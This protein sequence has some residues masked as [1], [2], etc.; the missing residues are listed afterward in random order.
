MASAADTELGDS[1]QAT[2]TLDVKGLNCPLPILKTKQRLAQ[3]NPGE[4][5]HILATDP[6]STIDFK[7]FCLRTPHELLEYSEQPDLFQF[8]I[9]KA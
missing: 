4:T 6:A 1:V 7:A 9:R 5:L 3:M 2:Y 8:L